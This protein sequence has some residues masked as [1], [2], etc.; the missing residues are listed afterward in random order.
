MIEANRT[1]SKAGHPTRNRD[2]CPIISLLLRLRSLVTILR[3][4]IPHLLAYGYWLLQAEKHEYLAD[5]FIE[6]LKCFADEGAR[7][8][9]RGAR[10]I[11]GL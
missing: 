1:I 2:I 4:V 7:P 5:T 8:V 3:S 6:R 9:N 11:Q 10:Q